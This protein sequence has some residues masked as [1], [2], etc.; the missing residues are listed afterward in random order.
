MPTIKCVIVGDGAVGKS[1]MIQSNT[2]WDVRSEYVPTDCDVYC[3]STILEGYTIDL[4]DMGGQ[5]HY[6]NLRH[7][8][9]PNTDVF[10]V[11]FSVVRPSTFEN[12]KEKVSSKE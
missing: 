8:Q 6:D 10:L 9:Y 4:R 3:V 2:L 1:C 12:V 11:C 5:A 7:L